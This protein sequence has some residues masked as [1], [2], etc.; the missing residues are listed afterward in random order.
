MNQRY[1]RAMLG[2]RAFGRIVGG[3]TDPRVRPVLAITFTYAVFSTFWVY[4][5][6]FAV[7]D[8]GASA[9]DVGILFLLCSPPAAIAN[10]VSGAISDRAGRKP[11][12]AG[13]FAASAANMALLWLVGRN[14]AVAFALIVLQ[15]VIGAPAYSLDRALVADVVPDATSRE[16]TFATV[17]VAGNAGSLLGPPLAALVITLGGWAAYLLGLAAVGAAGAAAAAIV[18]PRT[19]VSVRTNGASMRGLGLAAR[20]RAF[21]LLLLST[22]LGYAIYVGYETVLPVLAVSVYGV[23]ASTWGLL[24]AISPLLVIVGQLRL[25]RAVA[26]IGQGM[27]LAVSML[28]MGLP[29]L[30]LIAGSGIVVIAMA[31]VVFVVGEML[32]LP[33]SQT[34]AADLAPPELRGTYFGALAATTGPAWTLVPFA[35]LQ[36]RAQVGV[37]SVWLFFAGAA[38]AGAAVGVAAARAAARRR[39]IDSCNLVAEADRP[40]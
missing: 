32:W 3:E 8:L 10:L 37:P 17:R 23:G 40:T 11:L 7:K 28:L 12:I 19:T 16:E 13:S 36:L 2:T 21:R 14:T 35:A 33:T 31:L 9:S 29:F 39:L 22:S 6:V 25:T 24:L 26:G 5:G 20:D 18:L 34:L 1:V 4:V 15:G 27:R 38:V 30:A